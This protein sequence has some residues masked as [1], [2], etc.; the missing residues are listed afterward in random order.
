MRYDIS[1][2]AGSRLSKKYH[3]RVELQSISLKHQHSTIRMEGAGCSMFSSLFS[4]S[5]YLIGTLAV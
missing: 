4:F 2:Y 5:W 3:K 1:V